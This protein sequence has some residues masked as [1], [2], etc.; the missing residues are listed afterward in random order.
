M[1]FTLRTKPLSINAATK[2]RHFPTKAKTQYENI[3][4]WLLPKPPPE[5]MSGFLRVRYDFYLR[6]FSLTDVANLEKVL[7]DCIKTR[8]IILD[9]RLI[10]EITMRKY[11]SNEDRI[12]VE[13]EPAAPLG[14]NDGCISVR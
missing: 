8:G 10:V 3:L 12:E 13:I 1:K 11:R 4:R 6:N 14:D 9:D 7:T 5:P 2:G